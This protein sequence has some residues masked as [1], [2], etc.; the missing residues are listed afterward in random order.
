MNLRIVKMNLFTYKKKIVLSRIKTA[1]KKT[2]SWKV[3]SISKTIELKL[4]AHK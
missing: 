1:V 2:I 4:R 3:G